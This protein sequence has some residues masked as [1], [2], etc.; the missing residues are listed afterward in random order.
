[1]WAL[2]CHCVDSGRAT[3]PFYPPHFA[4]HFQ[5]TMSIR[6]RA[7][8]SKPFGWFM[9]LCHSKMQMV[10]DSARELCV[11]RLCEHLPR[12]AIRGSSSPHFDK[13][14]MIEKCKFDRI[15]CGI[16]VFTQPMDWSPVAGRMMQRSNH[17]RL[18]RATQWKM[19]VRK[20]L[21]RACLLSNR[22]R[23]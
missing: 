18:F 8:Q 3:S 2:I 5:L 21:K 15:N 16:F 11:W 6:L 13:L 19:C 10:E 14:F 23:P 7:E 12:Q 9:H 20:W 17:T 22:I 4:L 1:M